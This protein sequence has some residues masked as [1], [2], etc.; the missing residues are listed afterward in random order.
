MLDVGK[1]FGKYGFLAH[2]YCGIDNKRRP[3]P[4]R[5]MCEQSRITIDAVESNPDYLWPH[6]KQIY[7]EVYSG[8]IEDLIDLLPQ[9]DLVLMIDIIEHLDK[10]NGTQIV[11]AF[12]DKQSI[13]VISTPKT[14]FQQRLYESDD[15]N[16]LS[17]WAP[18]DFT[19]I[20]W[21][22]YQVVGP[23]RVF[24]LSNRPVEM[25]GFGRSLSQRIKRIAHAI[26]DEV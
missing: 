4:L 10:R 26:L 11:R 7:H 21:M 18:K 25:K 16:H 24:L 19:K 13:L 22:D 17:Y 14:F 5:T 8:R 6:I 12:L 1:G 15:E 9:Y 2:E 20:G 3:N 23:S